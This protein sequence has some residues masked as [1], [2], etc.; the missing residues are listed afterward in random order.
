MSKPK[1]GE[2][3]NVLAVP[4]SKREKKLFAA[5]LTLRAETSGLSSSVR[6]HDSKRHKAEQ[7]ADRL[8]RELTAT[9]F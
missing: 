4:L 2:V 7:Q 3:G 8:I 5:L 1:Q 9:I 6:W